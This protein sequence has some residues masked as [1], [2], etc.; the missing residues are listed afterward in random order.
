M[1]AIPFDQSS[2]LIDKLS[3][4]SPSVARHAPTT[5]PQSSVPNEPSILFTDTA[6]V[7]EFLKQELGCSTIDE[8]YH[9]M[10]Y[11]ARKSGS[12][13]DPLHEHLI[14]G[15]TVKITEN[16]NL[17]LVWHYKELYV[18][19]LPYCLF[20]F[21]F[22]E[23]HLVEVRQQTEDKAS[24]RRAAVGFV[25]SYAYLIRHESDFRIAQDSKLIPDGASY[26]DFQKYIGHFRNI[27]D[28]DVSPRWEFGQLRLTRLNWAVRLCQPASRKGKGIMQR[29]YYQEIYW[30]TGQFVQIFGAPLLFFF[31]AFSLILSAM[32]VVLAALE[33]PWNA[34]KK[35]SWGFSVAVIILLVVFSLLI[36]VVV[37]II[38]MSQF[39]FAWR[40]HRKSPK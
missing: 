30:Q 1:T 16:P 27:L 34:F 19:P 10:H 6:Q 15:R 28:D 12:H 11:V 33:S 8:L 36:I 31:A 3:S 14:R 4:A 21:L 38:L 22:W 39:C 37:A 9:R 24:I 2:Q 18:K 5:E 17:H 29:L 35:A 7:A 23:R 32:Q 25:R 20:S 40:S 26:L 13:I